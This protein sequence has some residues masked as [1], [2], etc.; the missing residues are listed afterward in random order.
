MAAS[1]HLRLA[2]R[3]LLA[4]AGFSAAVNLL[5]LVPALFMLQVFDRVLASGSGETLAVL[6]SASR[7]RC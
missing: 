2:R 7:S 5:L 6:C 4:V 1:D 3:P